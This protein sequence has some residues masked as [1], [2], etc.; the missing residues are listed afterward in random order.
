[1]CIHECIFSFVYESWTCVIKTS[2]TKSHCM[3]WVLN[4]MKKIVEFVQ[5]INTIS[6]RR[7][8]VEKRVIEEGCGD[9]WRSTIDVNLAV[10]I[11]F[12]FLHPSG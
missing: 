6:A 2:C 11:H 1:M 3:H 10:P 4:L 5:T 9:D 12:C 8:V 7:F